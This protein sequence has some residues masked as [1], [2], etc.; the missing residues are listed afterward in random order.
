MDGNA[1]FADFER[2]L[3]TTTLEAI[4]T[5]HGPRRRCPPRLSGYKLLAGLVYHVS[6]KGGPFGAHLQELTGEPISEAAASERR[7]A[8][9]W[10]V[11]AAILEAALVP[12]AEPAPHPEAFFAGRRLVG[13]DGTQF[14]CTN[15]PRI[16]GTMTKAA[17]RRFEAAFAKLGCAVLVELGTHAPLAAAISA[18]DLAE[19]ES[20]L[21]GELLVR[22]PLESLLLGDR[23]YGHGAFIGRLLA[24]APAG[25]EQAFLLRVGKPPK[26]KL[27]QRLP[28]GSALMEVAL[29][30]DEARALG[31]KIV[32]VREVRGRVRRPG[33][34]WSEVRLWTSLLDEKA[35]PA[36]ELLALYARR[37]EQE[38]AYR[39]LKVELRASGD[40]P[41]A[42]HTPDTAAQE[43]AALLVAMAMVARTRLQVAQ[44]AGAAPLRVSFG[45]TLGALQPLW[46]LLSVG[47]DL[48]ST[49]QQQALIERVLKQLAGRLLLRKR[50]ERGCARGL[51]QP[52][53]SWPRVHQTQQSKGTYQYEL[54]ST[55]E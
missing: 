24:T 26:P 39:E 55:D 36:L 9:P 46:M 53:K 52:V 21:A 14:S 28:D 50:R 19:S 10:E 34:V 7:L 27:V 35:H 42:S 5:Q 2:V 54:T 37:W 4:L 23:L 6:Q 22:L 51:R 13:I 43:I 1:F 31:T 20:A 17:S 25:R 47:G 41:L 16:L 15:T 45:R 29:G 44:A 11:F 38:I 12:L 8:M 30:P 3:P 18:P 32:Q 33:G 40:A 49:A 48:L